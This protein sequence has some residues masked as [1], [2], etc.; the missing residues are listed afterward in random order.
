MP[1][2][3][4]VRGIRILRSWE[5]QAPPRGLGRGEYRTGLMLLL[6]PA[7]LFFAAGAAR[8]CYE[9]LRLA[10]LQ[11]PR[12]FPTRSGYL[13]RTER[14]AYSWISTYSQAPSFSIVSAASTWAKSRR[15]QSRNGCDP[16]Y[17]RLRRPSISMRMSLPF[18]PCTVSTPGPPSI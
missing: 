13:S 16:Y 18:L 17:R 12:E 15:P 10:T 2:F 7:P 6:T 5:Y 14:M 3:T 9:Q 8:L 4:E 1:L 11:L